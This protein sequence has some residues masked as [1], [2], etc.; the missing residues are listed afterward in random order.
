MYENS[1][2]RGAF[3][4]KAFGQVFKG[5]AVAGVTAGTLVQPAA[6]QAGPAAPAL[7]SLVAYVRGG[8]VYVS[9]G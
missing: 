9:K 3:V 5:L 2:R 8:D 4:M 6:A 7:P 1:A